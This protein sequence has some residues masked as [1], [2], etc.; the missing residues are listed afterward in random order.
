MFTG[1]QIPETIAGAPG[2][3][4]PVITDSTGLEQ[5]SIPKLGESASGMTMAG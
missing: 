4:D 5:D 2:I 3:G 1:F